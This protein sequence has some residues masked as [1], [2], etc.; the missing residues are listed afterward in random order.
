MVQM[1]KR[2]DVSEHNGTIDWQKVAASSIDFA[3][4][5]AGLGCKSDA[6]FKEN[7]QGAAKAGLAEIINHG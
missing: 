4:I 7:I 5:R 3:V 1:Y 6:R 2:I